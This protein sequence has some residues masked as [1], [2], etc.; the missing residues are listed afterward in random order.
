MVNV[1]WIN[2]EWIMYNPTFAISHSI[3]PIFT[4]DIRTFD[5]LLSTGKNC[6]LLRRIRAFS[7]FRPATLLYNDIFYRL[8]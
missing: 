4:F 8:Q 6:S 3:T 5:I 7:F 2:I 1:E